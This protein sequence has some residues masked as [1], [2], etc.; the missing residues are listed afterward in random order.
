MTERKENKRAYEELK[1]QI[2]EREEQKKNEIRRIRIY[3]ND[4]EPTCCDP[5]FPPLERPKS[6][7]TEKKNIDNIEQPGIE[8]NQTDM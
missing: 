3:N 8:K 6:A 5:E 1:K 2:Q 7:S 4:P